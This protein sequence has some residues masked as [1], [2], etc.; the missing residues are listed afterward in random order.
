[1]GGGISTKMILQKRK[2]VSK[3]KFQIPLKE[4]TAQ[5]RTRHLSKRKNKIKKAEI[6]NC[7]ATKVQRFQKSKKN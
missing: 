4:T 5:Y 7:S 2:I 6:K 1:M 3:N